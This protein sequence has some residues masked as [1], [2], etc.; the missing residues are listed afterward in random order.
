LQ[1]SGRIVI[2]GREQRVSASRGST[3]NGRAACSTEHARGWDWIGLNLDDGG[4]LMVQRIRDDA[5]NHYWGG[6]T[7][8]EPGKPDRVFARATLTGRRCVAGARRAPASNI[9]S[10]GKC[11]GGAHDI[12]CAPCWTIRRTMRAGAPGRSTG[13]AQCARSTR[14][15]R[16]IG[17]GYLEL[18][19]YGERLRL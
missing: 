4:A 15:A 19:G 1:T 7:L 10:N 11:V 17:R 6:A 16:A 13:K 3:T 5:G 2:G 9:P 18:T 14:A 12:H 8:R